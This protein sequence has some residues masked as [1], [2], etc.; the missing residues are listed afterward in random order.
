[1]SQA[2]AEVV[3][4]A[5]GAGEDEGASGGAGYLRRDREPIHGCKVQRLPARTPMPPKSVIQMAMPP[6]KQQQSRAKR[7]Q[8]SRLQGVG[9]VVAAM[10][11]GG[12]SGGMRKRGQ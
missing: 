6:R 11:R 10:L 4:W 5:V 3:V 8:V 2:P 1:M 12:G 7:Q 9:A